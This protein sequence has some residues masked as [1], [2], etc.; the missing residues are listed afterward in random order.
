MSQTTTAERI[1]RRITETFAPSHLEVVDESSSHAVPPGAE[2]HF[3]LVVVSADFEGQTRLARHRRVYGCLADE[4]ASGV[5]AL[6]LHL[7]TEAEWASRH[8]D[9]SASPACRGG[10]GKTAA[11]RGRAGT[12]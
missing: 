8:G 1:R 9:V 7:F 11:A 12:A 3:K 6:A 4:L 10:D 5:H 2:S